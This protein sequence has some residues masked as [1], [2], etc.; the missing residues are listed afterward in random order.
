MFIPY[1][2]S[3]GSIKRGHENWLF[4]VILNDYGTN[5]QG[6]GFRFGVDV[7]LGKATDLMKKSGND[8]SSFICLFILDLG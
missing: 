7:R 6:I 1:D 5:W 3:A 8:Y 2:N 4:I